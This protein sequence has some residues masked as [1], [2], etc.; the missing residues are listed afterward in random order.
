MSISIA[1]RASCSCYQ[2]AVIS[3]AAPTDPTD[4]C[5]KAACGRPR[6]SPDLLHNGAHC[7]PRLSPA[8]T[9]AKGIGVGIVLQRAS[10][11]PA[12]EGK[13]VRDHRVAK[14]SRGQVQLGGTAG[15]RSAVRLQ[16][17]MKCNYH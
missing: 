10:E 9:R 8:P 14:N 12:N 15:A 5:E 3:G 4:W 6:R 13:N 1:G 16:R 7:P 11:F 17:A 2:S